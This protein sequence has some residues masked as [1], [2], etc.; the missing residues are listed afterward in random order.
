MW[1]C[2]LYSVRIDVRTYML[3][4]Y[5]VQ[6]AVMMHMCTGMMI[7]LYCNISLDRRLR[8]RSTSR[9]TAAFDEN[10]VFVYCTAPKFVPKRHEDGITHFSSPPSPATLTSFHRAHDS[11]D[12]RRIFQSQQKRTS[13]HDQIPLIDLS[14]SSNQL[15]P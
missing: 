7:K 8:S 6:A 15:L 1:K 2:I 3:V 5:V 11:F 13:S 10:G 14:T 12:T 4:N 9:Q